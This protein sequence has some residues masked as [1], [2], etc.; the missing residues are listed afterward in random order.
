[1]AKKPKKVEPLIELGN[2][3]SVPEAARLAGV[4][5]RYMRTLVGT[6]KVRGVKAGRNYLVDR[7]AAEAFERQPGMGRPKTAD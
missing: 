1:M 2:L 5:A 6:G 3:V 7:A 4:D